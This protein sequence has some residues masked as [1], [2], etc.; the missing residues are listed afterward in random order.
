MASIFLGVFVAL[1]F[2]DAVL[3]AMALHFALNKDERQAALA[4]D[5]AQKKEQLKELSKQVRGEMQNASRRR[6]IP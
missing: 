5:I 2:T 6:P 3:T 1:I 4:R